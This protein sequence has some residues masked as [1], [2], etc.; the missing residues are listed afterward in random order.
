MASYV[1][2]INEESLQSKEPRLMHGKAGLNEKD[3]PFPSSI[4]K[5]WK[6]GMLTN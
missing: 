2:H 1:N 6:E 3:L 4:E 5:E